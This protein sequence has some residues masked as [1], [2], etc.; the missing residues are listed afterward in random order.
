MDA[1]IQGPK[2][3]SQASQAS[4]ILVESGDTCTK[5]NGNVSHVSQLTPDTV[6]RLGR[7]DIFACH[8]CKF[9]GDKCDMQIHQYR[10]TKKCPQLQ[11]LIPRYPKRYEERIHNAEVRKFEVQYL[12]EWLNFCFDVPLLL[13]CGHWARITSGGFHLRARNI[14][15]VKILLT[16][17][18]I[19]ARI[20]GLHLLIWH[21]LL[22]LAYLGCVP[23]VFL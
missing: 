23:N 4:Q 15:H 2:N 21:P 18:S 17:I 20:Q 12:G 5:N 11:N 10:R 14:Q 6:Y 9:K 8:C 19:S 3:V 16:V 7:T 1:P 22:R 13:P